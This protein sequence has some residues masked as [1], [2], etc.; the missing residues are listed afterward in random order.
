[1]N[2]TRSAYDTLRAKLKHIK[3]KGALSEG[4][5]DSHELNLDT[6]WET[7]DPAQITVFDPLAAT[8]SPSAATH[9]SNSLLGWITTP[10]A[11]LS[12]STSLQDHPKAPK[13]ATGEITSAA[14][15]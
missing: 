15:M 13:A 11:P 9:A 6:F 5:A 7:V 2:T 3:A 1:M 8:N 12:S 14:S 4:C 10:L